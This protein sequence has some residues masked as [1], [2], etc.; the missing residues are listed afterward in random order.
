MRNQIVLVNNTE[1]GP[2]PRD[3]AHKN[4]TQD[5]LLYL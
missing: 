2:P 4:I 5:E 3:Y 1:I